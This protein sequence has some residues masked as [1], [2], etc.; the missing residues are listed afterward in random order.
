LPKLSIVSIN[1]TNCLPYFGPECGAC[2]KSCQISGA[3][4]WDSSKPR[5]NLTICIGWAL[6][7]DACIVEPK[8]IEVKF[9]HSI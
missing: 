8:A 1:P 5:I 7:R 9:L 6:C 3:L 2:A 4:F